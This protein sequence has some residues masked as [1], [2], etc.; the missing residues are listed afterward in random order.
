VGC[1]IVGNNIILHIFV[2]V[3]VHLLTSHN[4]DRVVKYVSEKLCH[5]VAISID[6]LYVFT[7]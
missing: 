1:I 6:R 2:G 4:I 5:F 3:C 7:S